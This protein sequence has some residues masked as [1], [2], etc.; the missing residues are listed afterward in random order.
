MK[1]ENKIFEQVR[2]NSIPYELKEKMK[3]FKLKTK[4][5]YSSQVSRALKIYFSMPENE[6]KIEV[7]KMKQ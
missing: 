6:K 3:A 4:L 5:N 1:K 2:I 7:N